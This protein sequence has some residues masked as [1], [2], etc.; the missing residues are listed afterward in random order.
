MAEGATK[1]LSD[2][3]TVLIGTG[4]RPEECYRPL[5]ETGNL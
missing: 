5:R 3:A 1:L 2:I 4:L